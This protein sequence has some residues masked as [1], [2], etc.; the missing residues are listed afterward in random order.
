MV[1]QNRLDIPVMQ[2]L[3]DFFF[4]SRIPKN[5]FLTP[6]TYDTE[7]VGGSQRHFI[8]TLERERGMK[9]VADKL[10]GRALWNNHTKDWKLEL[11]DRF[12]LFHQKRWL[13][14][15]SRFLIFFPKTILVADKCVE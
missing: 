9:Y 14:C 10:S 7:V 5:H 12:L 15:W 8:R 2:K 3:R 1:R 4:Q 11:V 13:K 6:N